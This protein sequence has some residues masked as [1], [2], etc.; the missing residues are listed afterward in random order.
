MHGDKVVAPL[1]IT[2]HDFLVLLK[3][4]AVMTIIPSPTVEYSMT[5]L[6]DKINSTSPP[7]GRGQEDRS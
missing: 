2:P 6:L 3:E 7:G 1:N 5:D 4:V